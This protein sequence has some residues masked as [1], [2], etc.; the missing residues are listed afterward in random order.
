MGEYVK[1]LDSLYPEWRVTGAAETIADL[2]ESSTFGFKISVMAESEEDKKENQLKDSDKTLFD[3]CKEGNLDKLK[4]AL[5]K[6][7]NVDEKKNALNKLD[8]GGM[9]LLMWACDRGRLDILEFLLENGA[10]VNAQDED[11]QTCLHYAVSCDYVDLVKALV[12]QTHQKIDFGLKDSSEQTAIEITTNQE[13][14]DA[15]KSFY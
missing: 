12:A 7:K 8:E 9:S 10:D 4:S 6:L 11:G 5:K 15:L 13:I 1:R 14:K 3:W 2:K